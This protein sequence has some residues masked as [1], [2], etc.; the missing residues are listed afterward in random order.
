[1]VVVYVAICFRTTAHKLAR[2]EEGGGRGV[3]R[4]FPVCGVPWEQASR[5][6]FAP[7]FEVWK[8]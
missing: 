8:V 2:G 7:Y 4:E 1:M 5:E 3:L 6:R